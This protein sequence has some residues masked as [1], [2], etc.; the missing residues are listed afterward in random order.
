MARQTLASVDHIL[1]LIDAAHPQPDDGLA[2]LTAQLPQRDNQPHGESSIPVTILYNKIDLLPPVAAPAP[3]VQTLATQ[4]WQLSV[5][6]KTGQGCVALEQH[7]VE[8]LAPKNLTETGFSARERHLVHLCAALANIK[9]ARQLLLPVCCPNC[10]LD[11]LSLA[12]EL[13]LAHHQLNQITGQDQ[14]QELLDSVFKNFCVG[15]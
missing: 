5:S 1:Y 8:Q 4:L 11:L 13:R 3:T 14:T 12:E 9:Q 7:L 15:K 2:F 6:F 10:T